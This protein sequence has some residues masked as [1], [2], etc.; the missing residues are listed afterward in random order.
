M[1]PTGLQL[2]CPWQ[3]GFCPLAA[4][5]GHFALCHSL[6]S[7]SQLQSAW[8]YAN[9]LFCLSTMLFPAQVI[10]KGRILIVSHGG[11]QRYCCQCHRMAP[12]R[13]MFASPA[14]AAQMHRSHT[15]T[16]QQWEAEQCLAG[17]N[18]EPCHAAGQRGQLCSPTSWHRGAAVPV[19]RCHLQCDFVT[20]LSPSHPP[21]AERPRSRTWWVSCYY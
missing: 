7:P 20:R 15:D 5:R 17:G 21:P 2:P 12:S 4:S 18:L 19:G 11:K 6:C 1:H 16:R 10:V 13:D 9:T 3:R 8:V 14:L